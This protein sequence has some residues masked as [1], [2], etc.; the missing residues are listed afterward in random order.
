[1]DPRSDR[2][3]SAQAVATILKI[4]H[5]EVLTREPLLTGPLGEVREAIYAIAAEGIHMVLRFPEGEPVQ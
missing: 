5:A 1:M 2:V 4:R 3:T